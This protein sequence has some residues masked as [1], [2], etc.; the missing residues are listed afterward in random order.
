MPKPKVSLDDL[1]SVRQAAAELN[2]SVAR[3]HILIQDGRLQATRVDHIWIIHRPD[4]DSV[5]NRPTGRPRKNPE[6][7]KKSS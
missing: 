6:A 5:R 4:L 7:K 1:L 2:C 3:V